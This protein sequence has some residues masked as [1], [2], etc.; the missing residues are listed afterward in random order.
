[1]YFD[2]LIT[3]LKL[4]F[5]DVEFNVDQ[6]G[7]LVSIPPTYPEF[8][9]IEIQDD[10]EEFIIFIGGFTHIHISCH[11]LTITKQ[12]R[13]EVAVNEVVEFLYDLFTDKIVFWGSSENGGGFYYP[14]FSSIKNNERKWLWS[15]EVTS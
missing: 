9:N 1:M 5:P 7:Y 4:E 11:D 2:V 8:G 14:E 10:N 12:K 15:G 3:K 13:V 6:S